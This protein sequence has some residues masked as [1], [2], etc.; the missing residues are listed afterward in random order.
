MTDFEN[1]RQYGAK[2]NAHV[3]EFHETQMGKRNGNA[4]QNVF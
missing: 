2:E 1:V 4:I 3:E